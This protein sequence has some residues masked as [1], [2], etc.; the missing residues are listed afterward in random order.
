[1]ATVTGTFQDLPAERQR[2]YANGLLGRKVQLVHTPASDELPQRIYTAKAVAV[3]V[4]PDTEN[5]ALVLEFA[6]DAEMTSMAVPMTEI[7]Q[8]LQQVLLGTACNAWNSGF[9]SCV[10]ARHNHKARNRWGQPH[11]N[12]LGQWYE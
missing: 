3:V 12:P 5:Y 1:M 4:I 11:R 8:L 7:T 2:G 9:G 6:S 10:L